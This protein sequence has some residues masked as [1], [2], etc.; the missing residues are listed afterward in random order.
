[1]LQSFS[2]FNNKNPA[3]TAAELTED[4]VAGS[5]AE[6]HTWFL[7]GAGVTAFSATNRPSKRSGACVPTLLM[8][9]LA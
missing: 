5:S 7:L 2:P 4:N 9:N 8:S 3:P 6:I 1:M